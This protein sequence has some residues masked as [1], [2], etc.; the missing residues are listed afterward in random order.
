VYDH[1]AIFFGPKIEDKTHDGDVPPSYVSLNVHEQILHNFMPDSG[2]SHNLMPKVI[3]ERLG[4]NI[5][6]PYKYIYPFDSSKVKCLGLI[7]DLAVS[8]TQIPSKFMVMDIVLA[9]IPLRYVMLLPIFWMEM[10]NESLQTYM[11][12]ITILV[13]GGHLRRLY[14]EPLM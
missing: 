7:K 3:M 13:F 5:T 11:S 2:A 10:L 8:L 14:M 12:Y 6:R 1:P 9:D 4:L